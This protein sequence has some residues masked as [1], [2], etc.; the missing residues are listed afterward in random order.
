[1]LNGQPVPGWGDSSAG[2]HPQQQQDK[3]GWQQQ[4]YEQVMQADEQPCHSTPALSSPPGSSRHR[5]RGPSLPER[6]PQHQQ[7]QHHSSREYGRQQQQQQQHWPAEGDVLLRPQQQSQQG[8]FAQQQ[9]QQ[10]FSAGVLLANQQHHVHQQQQPYVLHQ[11]MQPP[12][13]R[14]LRW[15]F[16]GASRGSSSSVSAVEQRHVT[17]EQQWQEAAYQHKQ[18]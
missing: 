16:N 2:S 13:Q 18:G 8:L 6:Q 17:G 14:M 3:L 4:R 12:Q 11:G 7:N 5:H 9:W 15:L 1:M 10:Q